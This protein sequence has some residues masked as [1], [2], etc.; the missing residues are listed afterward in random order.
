MIWLRVSFLEVASSLVTNTTCKNLPIGPRNGWYDNC[1]L[2][3]GT[4]TDKSMAIASTIV[5]CGAQTNIG[6]ISLGACKKNFFHHDLNFN[7]NTESNAEGLKGE[8]RI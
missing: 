3:T 8:N 1:F 6:A 4:E 7:C 5:A 2:A